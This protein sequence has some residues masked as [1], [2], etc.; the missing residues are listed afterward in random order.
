MSGSVRK[1]KKVDD[2]AVF[3]LPARSA[4]VVNLIM[5]LTEGEG[6]RER[7]RERGVTLLSVLPPSLLPFLSLES[8]L[9]P[10]FSWGGIR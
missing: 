4:N 7:E 6:G 5:D 3:R 8:F 10:L 9:L 2:A 1:K